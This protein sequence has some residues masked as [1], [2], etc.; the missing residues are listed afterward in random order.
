[1]YLDAT[2]HWNFEANKALQ[3]I[4]YVKPWMGFIHHTFDTSFSIYNNHQLLQCPEFIKSLECCKGLFVLS[5]YIR[6]Q[7]IKEFKSRN[8]TVKVHHIPHPSDHNVKEFS[9]SQFYANKD[10]KVLHIG[11]WLRNVVKFYNLEI[12]VEKNQRLDPHMR[13]YVKLHLKVK[14]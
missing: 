9:M 4:P 7:F 8:I 11:G 3:L 13:D 2:F 14:I 12:P 1:M 6:D 5:E 10:K